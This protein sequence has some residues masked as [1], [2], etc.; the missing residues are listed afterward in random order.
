MQRLRRTPTV[1]RRLALR[2]HQLPNL[3]HEYAP[4]RGNLP[5]GIAGYPAHEGIDHDRTSP[6]Q[7]GNLS[8]NMCNR[9]SILRLLGRQNTAGTA[10]VILLEDTVGLIGTNRHYHGNK[11]TDEYHQ[12][13]LAG[14]RGEQVGSRH[15]AP[16]RSVIVVG[17]YIERTQ[18]PDG[19]ITIKIVIIRF[20]P[21]HVDVLSIRMPAELNNNDLVA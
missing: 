20:N 5:V 6:S 3:T 8:A 1:D 11:T 18:R 19:A 9:A 7:A 10:D 17:H 21:G 16:W 4:Y 15:Y 14:G 13:L 12:L 2:E